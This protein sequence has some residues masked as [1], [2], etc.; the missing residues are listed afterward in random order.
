[1]LALAPGQSPGTGA[2]TGLSCDQPRTRRSD[3][4]ASAFDRAR[5][6]WLIT[7]LVQVRPP[8]P[9]DPGL[10][11]VTSPASDTRLDAYDA[12]LSHVWTA[13]A[14][15]R[16]VLLSGSVNYIDKATGEVTGTV[17]T[18]DLPDRAIYKP[19]GNRRFNVCPGCAETY[20][21]DA[22]HLIRAG[23]AGGKGIPESVSGHPV[24]FATFTAPS[25]GPVHSRPVR[26]HTCAGKEQCR[27]K[28]QPCH[29]RR[30]AG[31]CPHG[32]PL[33]CYRR[34]SPDEDCIGDPLCLDCYDYPA[35]VVWNA[36]AGELWR[37]TKQDI[38]RHL[39]ELAFHRDA[40]GEV[41]LPP[42][43]ENQPPLRLSHGKAAEYQ[44]RG[45]VHFHVLFRLDGTSADDPTA[46][47]SPPNG[48]TAADL[49]NAIRESAASISFLTRPHPDSPDGEGW[50]I[51]WGDQLDVR[52]IANQGSGVV[53]G[54]AV[55][56]YLA[57]YATKGTE[58]SGHASAR[59]N[60]VDALRL[61][62]D[63]Y[64]THTQRLIHA[65]WGIGHADGRMRGKATYRSLRRWAHMLGFGGHFLTKARRYSVTLT[66]LRQAR[67]AYRRHQDTGPDYTPFQRQDDIDTE[68]TII[69]TRLS[70]T[71]N[72]WH[73]FGD[74][75]LANTAADQARKHREAARDAVA[76]LSAPESGRQ[77]A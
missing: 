57:K 2:G 39:I 45:A 28:P 76:D 49:E 19:C 12:W 16:P 42:L 20:R 65:C 31:T 38:E 15:S 40:T 71:G 3:V 52:T 21:R 47:V 32:R 74:A 4:T 55:A 29:P 64:G 73:T 59:I 33:A 62:A 14:C 24:V 18:D 41:D 36:A 58:V 37:R 54:L 75:L 46:I 10:E 7:R 23:L 61:H 67:V 25:F 5:E 9:F 17:R 26:L 60:T 43:A 70:Y 51:T 48:I 8:T 27:C 72:G 11:E 34:H 30:D 6:G 63:Q 68:T 1:M 44:A 66:A 50:F 35:H 69:V 13:A 77:A 56:S 22:F 53:S